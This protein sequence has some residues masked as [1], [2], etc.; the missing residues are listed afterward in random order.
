[1][2]HTHAFTHTRTRTR[3]TRREAE[4]DGDTARADGRAFERTPA[5]KRARAEPHRRACADASG[6]DLQAVGVAELVHE[7]LGPLSLL[8]DALLVV[9]SDGAGELVVVHGG[10][11]L[12]L[13]PEAGHADAVLDLED[14]L[15]PVQP[16]D[17]GAIQLWLLQQL[18]Q[19]LP[20]VD[21]SAAAATPSAAAALF[22]D[23]VSG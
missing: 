20:Q 3:H 15:L 2:E 7:P 13:A 1:M 16:A 17:A 21:V 23:F 8:H 6:H 10:T 18:L 5:V 12:P 14:A 9:L 4:G 19:E 11:V 22:F